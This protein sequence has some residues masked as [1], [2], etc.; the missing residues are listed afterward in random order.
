M[1]AS[2]YHR[3]A[4]LRRKSRVRPKQLAGAKTAGPLP[5]VG[6]PILSACGGCS[7]WLCAAFQSRTFV[8]LIL[9]LALAVLVLDRR[10]AAAGGFLQ[11]RTVVVLVVELTAILKLRQARSHVV[12]LRRGHDVLRLR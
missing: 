10:G 6:R 1:F 8:L 7:P 2:A 5:R 11:L 4:E 12:K 9:L 3:S